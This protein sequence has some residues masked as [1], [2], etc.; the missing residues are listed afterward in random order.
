MSKYQFVF[1]YQNGKVHNLKKIFRFKIRVWL[2]AEADGKVP[3]GLQTNSYL[4]SL[5][6]PASL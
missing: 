6:G 1:R 3:D 4:T 2:E 5:P